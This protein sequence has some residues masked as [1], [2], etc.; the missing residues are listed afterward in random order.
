MLLE[1]IKTPNFDPMR[2]Q[3]RLRHMTH[4]GTCQWIQQNHEFKTWFD[5]DRSSG[6]WCYGKRTL[7]ELVP[8]E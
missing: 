8:W 3:K 5:G 1:L 6:L 7:T 2:E 4:K